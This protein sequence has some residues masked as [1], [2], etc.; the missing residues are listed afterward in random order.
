MQQVGYS[1][2]SG[3]IHT[4]SLQARIPLNGTIEV[5]R[6]CPLHCAHCYNN[7]PP[8]HTAARCAELTYE[9][10]CRIIDEISEAGCLWLLYTGGEVF[11]RDDFL[12]IY[13]YAKK[14][15]LL[16]TLFTNGV[17]IDKRIA[18]HLSEWPPFNIEIT[19][20][21]NTKETYERV[22]GVPNSFERCLVGIELLRERGLPLR[23]KTMALT[24][25]KHELEYMNA[26][27]ESLGLQF[28]FDAMINPRLDQSLKPL[29][30]RLPP[31]EAIELDL[32]D[33]KVVADWQKYAAQ[34]KG[35]VHTPEQWDDLYHCGA[36]ISGF[37]IDP[38][39]N[40]QACGF[41]TGDKW[42]L[43]LGS[44]R[45]GWEGVVKETRTKKI[46]RRTKCTD[47]EIKAL[48]GMCPALG[49]LENGDAE[50]PVD[51]L[52]RLG[53]LRTKAL[54]L[55]IPSHGECPYCETGGNA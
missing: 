32:R 12:D 28:R 48:C 8:N 40:L 50:E 53:H 11:L 3:R 52:C 27:A 41:C 49:E 9:E 43:R 35:P 39:G 7:L 23:L 10:H 6:R 2:F 20:Y 18:E 38:Y 4:E 54:G 16:I 17:L 26:F 44:F 15:G 46:T 36:G 31:E 37:S 14:K 13:T 34:F 42:D 30:V 5:T 24:I 19:V 33:Q 55:S 45:E 47:C 22:T 1:D 21:G 29:A 25:N 51:Y